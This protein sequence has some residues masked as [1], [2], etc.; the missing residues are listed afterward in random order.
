[1]LPVYS[2]FIRRGI[3]FYAPTADAPDGYALVTNG[4]RTFSLAHLQPYSPQLAAISGLASVDDLVAFAN[5]I[6]VVR[7]FTDG[8]FPND[9]QTYIPAGS[10]ISGVATLGWLALGGN[11]AGGPP[12]LRYPRG[13]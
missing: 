9:G 10:Y 3:T 6:A 1:M 4:D 8:L 5:L 2:G 13:G 12:F 7:L 11:S